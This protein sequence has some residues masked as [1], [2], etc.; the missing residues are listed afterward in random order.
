VPKETT[1]SSPFMSQLRLALPGS[2]V[3]KHRDAS[4]IGLLDCS[5]TWNKTISWIEFKRWLPSKE[6]ST[7]FEHFGA[8]VEI[9]FEKIAEESPTQYDMAKRMQVQ[10]SL[11]LYIVW[12]N[13]TRRIGVW[14]PN[15][16][17][18]HAYYFARTP[19]VVEYVVKRLHQI[20]FSTVL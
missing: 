9:P 2:E 8:S 6:W 18:T 14:E 13:R 19:E 12:V 15:T 1:V 5:V 7:R 16:S 11:C 17:P 3:V 4:M 10:A 20:T